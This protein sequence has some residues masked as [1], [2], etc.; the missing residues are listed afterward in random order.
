MELAGDVP[1]NA[2]TCGRSTRIRSRSRNLGSRVIDGGRRC[3]PGHS[4]LLFGGARIV[5]EGNILNQ[6]GERHD[7]LEE[8]G[9]VL[10]ELKVNVSS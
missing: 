4:P 3:L 2:N 9:I 7:Y 1:G 5:S 10:V 8:M 6:A